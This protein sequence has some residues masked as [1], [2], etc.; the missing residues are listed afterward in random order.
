MTLDE[1]AEETMPLHNQVCILYDSHIV[2]FM[3]VAQA[4]GDLF[5][6]VSYPSYSRNYIDED[7]VYAGAGGYI[8]SLK[9]CI[10]DERYEVMDNVLELNGS[11]KYEEFLIENN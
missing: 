5:Y 6:I 11:P 8:I 2:R 10:P 7:L 4:A 1:L 9:D 3:G